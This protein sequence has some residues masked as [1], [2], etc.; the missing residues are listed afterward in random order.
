MALFWTLW[1]FKRWSLLRAWGWEYSLEVDYGVLSPCRFLLPSHELSVWLYCALSPRCAA[2]SAA[3]DCEATIC[4]ELCPP[5][6]EAAFCNTWILGSFVTLVCGEVPLSGGMWVGW[7]DLWAWPVQEC[8]CPEELQTSHRASAK[9]VAY[10][11][12]SHGHCIEET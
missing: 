3:Q 2:S 5:G 7:W 10:G 4:H 12:V 9:S 6:S 1:N 8:L 11:D